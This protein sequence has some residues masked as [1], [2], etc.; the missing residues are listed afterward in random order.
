VLVCAVD[1]VDGAL[2][3]ASVAPKAQTMSSLEEIG[4]S[5]TEY[6]R[7]TLTNCVDPISAIEEFQDQN[8][9]LLPSLKPALH[10]LD[11]HGISR[12]DFHQSGDH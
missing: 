9:I 10:F 11:L 5:G 1:V 3:M 2:R 6:L 8:G 4:I 12:L 7:E